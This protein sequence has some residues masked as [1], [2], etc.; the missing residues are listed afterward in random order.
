[1]SLAESFAEALGATPP[2]LVILVLAFLPVLEVRASIP[3]GLLYYEMSWVNVFLVSFVGNLLVI[4]VLFYG[5]PVLELIA[6]KWERLA[7]F[8]D[9]V[10]AFTRRKHSKKTERIEEAS[11]FA[12]VALPLPGAGTWTA[13]LTAYVFGLGPRQTWPVVALGA[14]VE[15][16][17]ITAVVLT[18]AAAW[19]WLV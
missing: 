5:L 10:F 4:P 17:I 18:G 16:V 8:L 2:A 15:C 3:V 14:I 19:Q 13:M 7:R 6:R 1:M 12:I 9:K 11:L